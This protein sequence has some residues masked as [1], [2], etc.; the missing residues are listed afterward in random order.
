MLLVTTIAG[1][2]YDLTIRTYLTVVVLILAIGLLSKN[3]IHI[4]FL[5]T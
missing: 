1:I 4:S 2:V 3:L 5:G